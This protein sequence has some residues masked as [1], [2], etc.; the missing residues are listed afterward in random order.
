MPGIASGAASGAATGAAFGPWGA[1]AGAAI[2]GISA[3]LGKKSAPQFANYKPTDLNKAV[4]DTVAANQA[5]FKGASTLAADTNTFDLEQQKSMLESAMP[6]FSAMQKQLMDA[7]NQDMKS[8]MTGE[9]PAAMQANL[10]RL[11]AERGV[12]RGTSGNFNQF[13]VMRDMGVN[14]LDWQQASRTRALATL[15]SVYNVAPKVSPMSP[16]SMFIS[17]Q[18]SI[19]VQTRNNENQYS[20]DQAKYNTIAGVKNFNSQLNASMFQ[21]SANGAMGLW[22]KASS[23]GN[24]GG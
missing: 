17:P 11:G 13:S 18:D 19:A 4:S 15:Q 24:G 10:A 9:L 21:E 12:T 6:G 2:G 3:A 7:A 23:G 8:S 22:Q 20:V 5:N 1:L 16:Y 14:M